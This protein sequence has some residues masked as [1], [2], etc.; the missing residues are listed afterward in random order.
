MKARYADAMAMCRKLGN[1]HLFI[2][3]TINRDCPEMHRMCLPDQDWFHRA[4]NFNRLY[5]DKEKEF[6]KDV[7]KRQCF[8]PVKGAFYV[9]E[10]QDR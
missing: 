4:D 2:T 1:P 5:I 7:L 8:G 10:H 9:V 3:F 6:L